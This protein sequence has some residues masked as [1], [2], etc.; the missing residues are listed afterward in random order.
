MRWKDCR[1]RNKASEKAALVEKPPAGGQAKA[2]RRVQNPAHGGSPGAGSRSRQSGS[3]KP[4][5][6]PTSRGTEEPSISV[7]SNA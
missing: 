1:G 4:M 7:D 5:R 3:E 6:T 2:V